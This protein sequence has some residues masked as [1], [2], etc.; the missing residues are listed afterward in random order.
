MGLRGSKLLQGALVASVLTLMTALP[1][2]GQQA[3]GA[4]RQDLYRAEIVILERKVNPDT[5][6]EQMA[7]RHPQPAAAT[8]GQLW[9]AGA[10]G[11]G[12]TT[13]NLVPRNELHLGSAASRLT[14]SGRYKVLLATGWYQSFPTDYQGQPL[15]VGLGDWLA[16]AGHREIEGQ[17]TVNRQRYLHV[18]VE[19]NHWR[20]ATG[21]S[22]AASQDGAELLTWIRE[23]RRMRSEEIHF[24]DSPTIGVLVFF[25]KI[26]E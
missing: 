25:R 21:D 4:A 9:V 17:I 11:Q 12:S 5:I 18:N 24:L 23:T 15:Q 1:A 8:G 16:Q 3:G 22:A 7:S 20:T 2:F 13:L 6:G 10:D 14:N 19:L 26:D